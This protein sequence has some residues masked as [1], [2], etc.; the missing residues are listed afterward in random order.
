MFIPTARHKILAM[1][2]F[3]TIHLA[4]GNCNVCGNT[5]TTPTYDTAKPSRANSRIKHMPQK[6]T[7]K[8]RIGTDQVQ[9]SDYLHNF[10]ELGYIPCGMY[11]IHTTS[12]VF[13][14]ILNFLIYV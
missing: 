2:P 1:P 10:R 14:T 6:C 8:K 11:S 3:H 4:H 9:L 7:T 13:Y 12:Y 5:G